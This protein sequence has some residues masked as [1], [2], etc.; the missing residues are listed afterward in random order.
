M[1]SSG[2]TGGWP[3]DV[4]LIGCTWFRESAGTGD[5]QLRTIF[6]NGTWT[7][8]NEV[9]NVRLAYVNGLL[10]IGSTVN[11]TS[12]LASVNSRIALSIFRSCTIN[13]GSSATVTAGNCTL[14]N[15]DVDEGSLIVI[16][17]GRGAALVRNNIRGIVR[18]D[19]VDYELKRDKAGSTIN[20]N[21]SIADLATAPGFSAVYTNGN[22]RQD[23]KYLDAAAENFC[24][25]ADSPNIRAA[26]DNVNNIGGHFAQVGIAVEN[27]DDGNAAGVRVIASPEINTTI[28]DAY[29]LKTTPVNGIVPV[30][31]Y[32]DYVFP[33][34]GLA[35]AQLKVSDFFSFDSDAA[36]GSVSNGNVVDAQPLTGSYQTE[37]YA[38]RYPLAWLNGRTEFVVDAID[39]SN[40]GRYWPNVINANWCRIGNDI[41]QIVSTRLIDTFNPPFVGQ[42]TKLVFTVNDGF[43]GTSFSRD[44]ALGT[45]VY[46]SRQREHL[47]IRQTGYPHLTTNQANEAANNTLTVP[48]YLEQMFYDNFPGGRKTHVRV[49][50]QIREVTS[51]GAN[52]PV[53]VLGFDGTVPIGVTTPFSAPI[54]IGTNI[55]IGTLSEISSLTPNRLTVLVR[56]KTTTETPT[57]GVDANGYPTYVDSEWNN[58]VSAAYGVAGKFF[59]QEID[60][61]PGLIIQGMNIWGRGDSDAPTG[62]PPQDLAGRW[63]H[64]R[65]YKRHNYSSI[66]LPL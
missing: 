65:V 43:T 64:V 58:E 56:S 33:S 15:S 37:L 5:P 21:P 35:I 20:P 4:E 27:T 52:Y 51:L 23:P 12:T 9:N 57:I 18:V 28:P 31:G 61:R 24:L 60:Q 48:R 66:G 47:A 49:N 34:S 39:A 8:R 59:Q 40:T 30:E 46:L 42:G 41:R 1:S 25:Q 14:Q 62:I 6:R 16:T 38:Y 45:T 44:H 26:N 17:S 29:F 50:G 3:Y 63:F 54:T 11:I 22:F 10:F 2:G 32:V 53:T 13:V 19:G 36:G 55:T 7:I